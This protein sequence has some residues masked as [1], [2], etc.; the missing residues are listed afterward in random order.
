MDS[1]LSLVRGGSGA[2]PDHMP[3]ELTPEMQRS[4]SSQALLRARRSKKRL[5]SGLATPSRAAMEQARWVLG[6]TS[7]DGAKRH[8]AIS[9]TSSFTLGATIQRQH[10]LPRVALRKSSA[11]TGATI[12]LE[13]PARHKSSCP[14]SASSAAECSPHSEVTIRS[15]DARDLS[16]PRWASE[17][18]DNLAAQR[19]AALVEEHM[20]LNAHAGD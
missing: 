13:R 18:L 10:S 4:S 7:Q 19:L 5:D 9:R 16:L 6:E 17:P 12:P 15:F 1:S 14:R 20:G 2:L 3:P 11:N 8:E